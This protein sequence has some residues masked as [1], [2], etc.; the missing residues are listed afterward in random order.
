MIDRAKNKLL[1]ELDSSDFD[2]VMLAMVER[3][4]FKCGVPRSYSNR[5]GELLA[6]ICRGWLEMLE[7]AKQCPES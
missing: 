4:G 6:E 5:P 7:A 2:S 1:L 3:A